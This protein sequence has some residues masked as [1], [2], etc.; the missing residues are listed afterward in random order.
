M[1]RNRN[2]ADHKQAI[3]TRGRDAA[4]WNGLLMRKHLQGCL[5][6]GLAVEI[7]KGKIQC[8]NLKLKTAYD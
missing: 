3:A 6:D 1:L 8:G 5:V 4:V 2:D 7:P